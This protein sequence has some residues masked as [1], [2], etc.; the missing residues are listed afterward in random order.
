MFKIKAVRPE[1]I[2]VDLVLHFDPDTLI[3]ASATFSCSDVA[4]VRNPHFFVCVAHDAQAKSGSWVPLYGKD[5]PGRV[6]IPRSKKTGIPKWVS[7]ET[8]IHPE[9]VWTVP[10]SAVPRAAR[11][12]NDESFQGERN[13]LLKAAELLT[14]AG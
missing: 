8:F 1:E 5:G 9:Q 4:R 6:A 12:G 2:K 3:E 7:A 11:A 14:P 10:D 13:R